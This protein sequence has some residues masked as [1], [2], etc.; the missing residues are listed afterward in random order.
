MMKVAITGHSAGLGKELFTRFDSIGF[1][2][3]NGF[4]IRRP[5]EI[6]EKSKDCDIFINNAYDEHYQLEMFKEIE[7]F[8]YAQDKLIINIS[9]YSVSLGKEN[10]YTRNKVLLEEYSKRSSCWVTTVR[11]SIMDTNFVRHI[12][13]REKVPPAKVADVIEYI[14]RSPLRIPMIEITQFKRRP[15]EGF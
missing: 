7:K 11:P 12:T 3:T 14:I 9:S 5:Q 6:A 15:D 2:L 1:D 4:T 8:W 10:S 13:D